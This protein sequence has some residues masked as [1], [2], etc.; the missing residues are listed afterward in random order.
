M[1]RI[2]YIYTVI[3]NLEMD[4]EMEIGTSKYDLLTIY[5]EAYPMCERK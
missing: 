2:K 3:I 5:I 4:V 1:K